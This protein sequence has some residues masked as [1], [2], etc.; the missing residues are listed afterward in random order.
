MFAAKEL[1]A[2]ASRRAKSFDFKSVRN[3]LVDEEVAE[4]WETIKK[5]KTT[6]RLQRPKPPDKLFEDR[7][8]TLLYRLGFQFLSGVGGAYQLLNPN[9]AKTPANQIDAVAID[10][11]IGLAIECKS[12][13]R[14]R[15]FADFSK[16]LAKHTVL[17]ENFAKALKVL[18][19]V[20]HRRP[21][22]FTFW[23][24][25][26]IYTENDRTRATVA[27]VPVLEESDLAYYEGLVSQIGEAARYQFLA[28]ILRGRPVPGLE[29]TVAAIRTKLA[30]VTAYS[31]SVSPEYLLKIAFV[32]HRARGKPSDI[33]AYQRMLK[34]SRL[35][36]IRE[37]ITEGGMFPTN[38]VV[39]IAD[40]KWVSFDRGKQKETDGVSTFGW[41]HIR[42]AYRVA[43]I[44][45]GQHRLFAYAGHPLAT[46]SVVSVMAFVGLPASEQARL[47]V[48]INAEQRKVKQS[49]LQELYA[50]LHWDADDPEIRLQAILSKVIQ[51]VDTQLGSPF[52][53]RILKA[54]D[55]RTELRCISLT[56]VFRA[57]ERTGFFIAKV[58]KGQV[59]EYGPLWDVDN[60]GTMARTSRLLTGY[61]EVLHTEASSLWDKGA[62]EG[63]GLAMND[64]VT[65]CVNVLKSIVHHLE[66]VR[67]YKLRDLTN[68][69]LLKV[70]TPFAI[71]VGRY[72]GGM[73]GT[74]IGQFRSLRGTQGQ[75]TGTRRVEEFIRGA[76][77]SFDPPGLSEFLEREKAQTTTRAFQVIQRI[78][79]ALQVTVLEELKQEFGSEEQGWYFTG[80][81]KGVRKKV[82]DRINEEGGKKGGREENFD[83]IDYREIMLAN[84]TTFEPIFAR[85]K[86]SKDARTK[87]IVQVNDLRKPVMHASKGVSLP[88]TEEQLSFLEETLGWLNIQISEPESTE[89]S[90]E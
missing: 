24:T 62:G 43:W 76:D 2:L 15:K 1:R 22:I 88:I 69:E 78:E 32:S 82:D 49:L 47:F 17:R 12:S 71:V 60:S 86:G 37:Y 44:I 55:T 6:T 52:Q 16:E 65:V 80:V 20:P 89:I 79:Q 87:W 84:W 29:L 41:L 73:S 51:A 48:D 33:D 21:S 77:P 42:P 19:P 59:I 81:P 61:F 53:G 56:S 68:D 64:G 18:Y 34:K 23:S 85:G 14:P 63:G 58:K 25:G 11:E 13:A 75:T 46:R 4:G 57:L 45:D 5:N 72:F 40:S 50:E 83:L 74:Q 38:I 10:N 67:G 30:G 7:V 90:I 54:D 39:N 3:P 26:F 35:R 70:V 28:D 8:W 66:K 9:D 27:G 31:F 36:N